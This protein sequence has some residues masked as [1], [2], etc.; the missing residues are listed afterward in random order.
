M[1]S[2]DPDRGSAG[3]ELQVRA[4]RE[5]DVEPIARLVRRAR[6]ASAMPPSVHDESET[7]GHLRGRLA[8]ADGW[9][10]ALGDSLVGFALTTPD[11]LEMLFVDPDHAGRGVG[12]TLL[13]L[14]KHTHPDG[15]ALWVFAS[16]ESARRFYRRHGLVELESTDGRDNEEQ[17]P[18]V[19]MAWAGPR[20]LNYLRGQVD[21]ADDELAA[22]ITRRLALTRE[23]Q[24][25]K[26]V[27]GRQGR[28]PE[29]EEEIAERLARLAPDL[30]L[31]DWRRL[32]HE[33]ISVSL[34]NVERPPR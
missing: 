22:V 13:D 18:D 3:G 25:H 5:P 9:V 21:R 29:R 11:W 27:G 14:V 2:T 34:D 12:S 15:F 10:A 26:P 7:R 19:R 28:D 6:A 20:P 23:I 4:A 8:Q 17:E 24:R 16:N 33:I 31:G 32:V 30:A 1:S